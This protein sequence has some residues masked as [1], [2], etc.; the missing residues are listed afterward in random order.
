MLDKLADHIFF[1]GFIGG[2]SRFARHGPANL[3]LPLCKQYW[4][5][6]GIKGPEQ[7]EVR[8]RFYRQVEA[9][10]VPVSVMGLLAL[11]YFGLLYLL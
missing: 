6:I 7:D 8:E 9:G 2:L 5:F 1:G 10:V 3:M 11:I 4:N